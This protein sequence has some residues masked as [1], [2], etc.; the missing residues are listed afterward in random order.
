MISLLYSFSQMTLFSLF[1][2]MQT[3][4]SLSSLSADDYVSWFMEN[5]A[6]IIRELPHFPSFSAFLLGS[7]GEPSTPLSN[8]IPPLVHQTPFLLIC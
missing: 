5:I 8:A 2:H 4:S 7:M 6:V 3:L 1:S